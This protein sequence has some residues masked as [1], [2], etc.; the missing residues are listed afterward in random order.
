M[1]IIKPAPREPLVGSTGAAWPGMG[2]VNAAYR[3]TW[4]GAEMGAS[5]TCPMAL[6]GARTKVPEF[7]PQPGPEVELLTAGQLS[8]R[9]EQVSPPGVENSISPC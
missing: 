2:L 1:A 9:E 7:V 5:A 8:C 6:F 4:P 3:S